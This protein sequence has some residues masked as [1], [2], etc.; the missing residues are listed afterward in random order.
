MTEQIPTRWVKVTHHSPAHIAA[1]YPYAGYG[2]NLALCQ[3]QARCSDAEIVG[4]GTLPRPRLAFA[5][6]ATIIEDAAADCQVG[7]YRLSPRDVEALDRRE[8]LG[9]SY[10]RYLVTVLIDG[11]ETRCFTYVKIDAEIRPPLDAYY[12]I[13]EEGYR[14]WN[15]DSAD[16]RAARSRA[17]K[18][19]RQRVRREAARRDAT[20]ATE[21]LNTLREDREDWG[22]YEPVNR[23]V[24]S[25]VTGRLRR[26]YRGDRIDADLPLEEFVRR[27]NATRSLSA[28]QRR[29]EFI[30]MS[31]YERTHY[32]DPNGLG[33][34]V[35]PANG[36]RWKKGDDGVWRR[37]LN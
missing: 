20:T 7:V 32:A 21:Y 26:P 3:M 14:D 10:H 28:S 23:H 35:N 4:A 11:V 25:L 37:T 17:V 29:R 31:D 33:V 22:R 16:L 12:R 19:A 15:F 13:I 36:Q 27:V 9:R 24:Y 6:Y 1:R 30:E 2:S 34:Y 18:T 8:G 5:H